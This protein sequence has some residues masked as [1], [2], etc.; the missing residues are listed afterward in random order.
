MRLAVVGAHLAGQ[1]LHHQ[2]SDRAAVL[3]AVTRTAPAYRLWDLGTTPAKPGLVR[4]PDAGAAIVVEVWDLGGEAFAGF[5]DAL[6]TPMAIGHVELGDGSWV[7]GF[8]VEPYA[9]TG[10][11]EIT[12]YGGWAAYLAGRAVSQS[13]KV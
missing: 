2:L 12:E 9:L 8:L 5:V 7:N 4:D 1:P 11:T 3:V 6:A 10:A 13:A